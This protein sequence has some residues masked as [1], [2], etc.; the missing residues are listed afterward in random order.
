MLLLTADKPS[1]VYMS[2]IAQR[3]LYERNSYG[4][5]QCSCRTGII[6]TTCVWR[7]LHKQTEFA[8]IP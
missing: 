6:I 3:Y 4:C 5:Y 8:T 1:I 2:I 7:A